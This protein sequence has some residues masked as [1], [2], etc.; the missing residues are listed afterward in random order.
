MKKKFCSLPDTD[1]ENYN[2]D[3]LTVALLRAL[4]VKSL[5]CLACVILGQNPRHQ[6]D[7][8]ITACIYSLA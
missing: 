8:L 4:L 5:P 3:F 6:V 7:P 1:A 2:K